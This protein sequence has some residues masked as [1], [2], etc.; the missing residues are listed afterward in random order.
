MSLDDQLAGHRHEKIRFPSPPTR[1][2]SDVTI[3]VMTDEGKKAY[4]NKIPFN[5]MQEGIHYTTHM[6]PYEYLM[7]EIIRKEIKEEKEY[8]RRNG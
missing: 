5:E 3:Y 2:F 1:Q 6:I 8:Y 7:K 4:E